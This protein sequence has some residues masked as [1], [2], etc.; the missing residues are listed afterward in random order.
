MKKRQNINKAIPDVNNMIS[1]GDLMSKYIFLDTVSPHF[2][3]AHEIYIYWLQT[4]DNW[5]HTEYSSQPQRMFF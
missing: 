5:Y 4:P 2:F 1:K 3:K